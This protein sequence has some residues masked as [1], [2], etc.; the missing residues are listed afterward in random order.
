MD[1]AFALPVP[2]SLPTVRR[3]MQSRLVAGS[4]DFAGSLIFVTPFL[5]GAFLATNV[6]ALQFAIMALPRGR[7]ASRGTFCRFPW[8]KS[9]QPAPRSGVHGAGHVH[10]RRLLP[11]PCAGGHPASQGACRHRRLGVDLH[12][13]VLDSQDP[14]R[15]APGHSVDQFDLRDPYRVGVSECAALSRG[16]RV[17]RGPG[18]QGRG[19][20]GVRTI[21]RSGGFC[22][23]PSDPR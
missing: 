20:Q 11:R 10:G 16:V 2:Q 18:V 9:G 4:P 5:L 8:P 12:R 6:P 1:K 22:S 7:A 13:H 19:F 15:R 14:R 21:G 17:R 3:R 23:G